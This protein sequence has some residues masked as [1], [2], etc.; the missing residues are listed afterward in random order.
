MIDNLSKKW[1][2]NSSRKINKAVHPE[3]KPEALPE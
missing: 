2:K 3:F 1:Q